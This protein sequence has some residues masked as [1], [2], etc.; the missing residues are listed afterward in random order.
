MEQVARANRHEQ[1]R[2]QRRRLEEGGE[3]L[4]PL[5][6]LA[7]HGE[8]ADGGRGPRTRRATTRERTQGIAAGTR[9]AHWP[10]AATR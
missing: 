9:G 1:T 6:E 7:A 5:E 2:R 4:L 10:A 8:E 3:V